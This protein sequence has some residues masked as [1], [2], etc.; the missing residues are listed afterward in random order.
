MDSFAEGQSATV[1]SHIKRLEWWPSEPSWPDAMPPPSRVDAMFSQS[2]SSEYAPS[3]IVAV[4]GRCF[5]QALDVL[6]LSKRNRCTKNRRTPCAQAFVLGGQKAPLSRRRLLGSV[7]VWKP[8]WAP[9]EM[10]PLFGCVSST[11]AGAHC[12]TCS[13]RCFSAILTTCP[14]EEEREG[15]RGVSEVGTTNCEG[16]Q[17]GQ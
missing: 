7:R 4:F 13:R 11:G 1:A 10:D 15:H 8:R 16:D 2:P 6:R 12:V 14:R 17:A 3:M 9:Y 5:V